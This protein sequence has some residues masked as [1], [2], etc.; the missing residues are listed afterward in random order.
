MGQITIEIP[1]KMNRKY[2][3]VSESSAKEVLAE[4]EKLLKKENKIDDEEIL[5]LWA[6]RS[7]TVEEIAEK[8]RE[9]SNNRN[10]KK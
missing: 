5:G 4:L 8:L 6:D 7:E 3:I 9:S 2:R 10:L 1:Q